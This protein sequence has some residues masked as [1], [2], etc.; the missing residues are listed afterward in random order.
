MSEV[1]FSSA[2]KFAPDERKAAFGFNLQ[3]NGL[4]PIDLLNYI[5]KSVASEEYNVRMF[6]ISNFEFKRKKAT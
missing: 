6:S 1:L 4:K 2:F 3:V 5:V